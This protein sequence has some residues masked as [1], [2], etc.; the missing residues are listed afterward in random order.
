MASN[1]EGGGGGGGR[2]CRRGKRDGKK[3]GTRIWGQSLSQSS[4]GGNCV[5]REMSIFLDGL[6][7]RSKRK[8]KTGRKYSDF[9][10]LKKI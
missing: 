7:S 9:Y 10:P 4:R 8:G 3:V 2:D 6:P 1:E 5:P